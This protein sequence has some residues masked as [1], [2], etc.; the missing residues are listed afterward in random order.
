MTAFAKLSRPAMRALKPGASISEHGITFTRLPSGD[1]RWSVNIMVNRVRH[2]R[3]VGTE[4]EG[5]TRT[6]AEDVIAGLKAAKRER[7][8][9]VRKARAVSFREAGKLY[10][11][12]LE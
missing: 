10:L 3:V 8:H 4:T 12:H 6:Q 7:A 9:G 11:E 2:H 5:F 1:G